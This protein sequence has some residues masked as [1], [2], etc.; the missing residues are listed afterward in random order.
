VRL[1]AREATREFL[2]SGEKSRVQ[3]KWRGEL[4]EP[5][6]PASQSSALHWLR[7]PSRRRDGEGGTPKSNVRTHR[8]STSCKIHRKRLAAFRETLEVRT[9]HRVAFN[10]DVAL[11]SVY[12]PKSPSRVH[13]TD[14]PFRRWTFPKKEQEFRLFSSSLFQVSSNVFEN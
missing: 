9:R 5:F 4:C 13:E 14:S 3:V 10:Q 1:G 11:D 6:V 8:T 7:A 12:N 2:F